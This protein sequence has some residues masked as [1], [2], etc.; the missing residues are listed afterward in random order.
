MKRILILLTGAVGSIAITA[1][2]HHN[3]GA[4]Y[5]GGDAVNNLNATIAGTHTRNPHDAIKVTIENELGEPEAWTIQWRGSRGGRG[6]G[7]NT[8]QYDFN[9]GDEVIID[10]RMARNEGHKLIQM[11][12]L[13]RPFD[14]WVITASQGR[15]GRRR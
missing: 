14:G 5:N 13:V 4:V 6:R 10:G 9:I 15:G 12:S 3:W 2:A 1:Q 8:S 11:T 7:D